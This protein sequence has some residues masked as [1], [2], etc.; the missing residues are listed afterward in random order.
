MG[1]IA[2]AIN[3]SKSGV[4][5]YELGKGNWTRNKFSKHWVAEGLEFLDTDGLPEFIDTVYEEIR[6]TLDCDDGD[7]LYIFT[8]GQLPEACPNME[9]VGSVYREE[10]K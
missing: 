10:P 2:Y 9:I 5:A 3:K 7:E 6:S 8:D 4:N 1:N